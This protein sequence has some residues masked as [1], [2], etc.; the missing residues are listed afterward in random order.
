MIASGSRVASRAS[1]ILLLLSLLLA[2]LGASA[3]VAAPRLVEEG[4]EPPEDVRPPPREG[5]ADADARPLRPA[6][7]H[8]PADAGA[9]RLSDVAPPDV[10]GATA[11]SAVTDPA[12]PASAAPRAAEPPSAAPAAP[13]GAVPVAPELAR[14]I[15]P[16]SVTYDALMRRFAE[17]RAALREADPARADAAG[18]ALLAARRELGIE[19]LFPL[20]VAEIRE[21]A[22][23]LDSN[24]AAEAVAH[25]QVA[26]ELAPDLPD[27][28]LALAR[29]RLAQVPRQPAPIL[30]AL[31]DAAL[32]TAREP[33]VA[34]AFLGDLL[35]AALAA[36]VTAAAAIVL[37]LLAARLRLVL[38]DFHH[39]PLLRGTAS[40]QAGFLALVLLGMPLAFGLGPFA[41]L[42]AAALAAWLY[43][44]RR[45]RL[46]VTVA[47]AV[48]AAL[49]WAAASAARLTIWTGTWAE[50]VHEMEHGAV[51][52]GEAAEI[53]R[54]AA[55]APAPAAVYAALGRHYKR[56]GKLD[57]A[58]RWYD[59]ARGADPRAPEV[60]VDV[61]N[62][63][64]LKGDL[65]G[66]KAAYLAATDLAGGDLEVLA[67]ANY[68]LS[69]LYLRTADMEKSA[70]AREKAEGQG[71]AWLRSQ[72]SD[73][74][75][76]A[77]RYL[78]DV[79]VP[80]WKVLALARGD[81]TVDAIRA[82][83]QARIGGPIRR[84]AWPYAVGGVLAALWAL[85][86]V[87]RQLGPARACEKCGGPACPRCD[88]AAGPLCGQCVNV[89][90]RKGVVEARDRLRKE[91]QVRRHAQL[92]AATTRI[93]AIV[94]GGA[95]HVW[96]G[97]VV[98]GAAVLFG[99]LF[100]GF[101]VWF[102][103]GIMPPPQPSPYVLAGKLA[104]AAPAAL[105]L[106]LAAVRGAFR[107]T[108]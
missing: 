43:L 70:A 80:S 17:R 10:G 56:R 37:L 8:R 24:L 40:A 77:N 79:P 93:L 60:Q 86:L 22:R 95:G 63:L 83:T 19:N 41:A 11:R 49:P 30:A 47:L 102:W 96:H 52:D 36:A 23:G 42:S 32:A 64:F 12:Q 105:L 58:L 61:A 29:A 44:S 3:Q 48:L 94:G 57:E 18:Q 46:V 27:A 75:F 98:R 51:S 107:R 39:L 74:D 1:K 62:A 33:H 103:R 7:Q 25:A 2:A 68:G 53:A 97:A 76:S 81:A 72:G 91:A 65:E 28:Y 14:R 101:V 90:T 100:L 82:W 50:R 69:K 66:A 85:A 35:S 15:V 88:P 84:S 104:V 5:S 38:H 99:L 9:R 34:R 31:R 45:E 21:S 20:A 73:E 13:G 54:A 67:A 6:P 26:V 71:G 4:E 87:G 89:F 92:T 106:W 108:R 16:V 78:V 55:G 59:A